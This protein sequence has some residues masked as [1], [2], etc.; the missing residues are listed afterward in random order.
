MRKHG[1]AGMARRKFRPRTTDSEHHL[2]I[3]PNVLG[4]R[5][6]VEEPNRAWVTDITYV[7]TL[8][9]WLY[10]SVVLDLFSRRVIGWSMGERIDQKLTLG[11]LEM[12]IR[13]RGVAKGVIHHSDRGCQYAA[14]GYRLVLLE[15]GLVA[16]MSRKG[17]CWD[18]A[19][20]ESFFRTLKV[21]CCNRVLPSR[22]TAR[23]MIFDFIECF[24][25]RRRRHSS[26]GYVSPIDFEKMY[27]SRIQKI[28]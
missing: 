7:A 16:S 3:A 21:E 10:L 12:A 13:A 22:Q 19:V 20:A 11:A 5:F 4:R 14:E 28:A 2:P 6:D 23:K 17:N 26:L 1:I 18:N 24:Y 27:E 9:G 25:N 15:H 8:E